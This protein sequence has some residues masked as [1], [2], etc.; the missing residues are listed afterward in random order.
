MK[1]SGSAWVHISLAVVIAV[2]ALF[3]IRLHDAGGGFF[4]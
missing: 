2:A 1:I 3:L 4:Q